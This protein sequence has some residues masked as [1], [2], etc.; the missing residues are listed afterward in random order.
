MTPTIHGKVLTFNPGSHRYFWDGKPTFSVTTILNRMSKQA[1][2]QW[3]AD[4]AIDHVLA[5]GQRVAVG[6]LAQPQLAISIE[7]VEAGRKAHAVTRDAAGDVGTKLHRYAKDYMRGQV[8]LLPPDM[9]VQKAG[10]AFRAWHSRSTFGEF[11]IERPIFS[12]KH[13]YAGTP[14][15][16]GLYNGEVCVL[17]Y[18]TGKGVY[19]EAWLQLMAYKIAIEEERGITGLRRVVVHLDKNTGT[20]TPMDDSERDEEADRDAWLSL[21]ALDKAMRK[22]PSIKRK[23]A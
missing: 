7:D 12:L 1:L 16:W 17:D 5:K 15:F 20:C 23:A 10:E 11:Q 13:Y 19:H 3:A 14:D 8:S 9:Q 6:D 2:I 4:Q 22:M 21:V 18:K